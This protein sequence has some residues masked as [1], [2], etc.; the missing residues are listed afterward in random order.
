MFKMF[1]TFIMIFALIGLVSAETQWGY[2]ND[3]LPNNEDSCIPA[4]IINYSLIPTVNNTLCWQGICID[5]TTWVNSFGFLTSFTE[6]DPYYFSNPRNYLN[7]TTLPTLNPF[8]QVLNTTSNVTFNKLAVTGN[9]VSTFGSSTATGNYI[10]VVGSNADATYDVFWGERKYPRITLKDTVVTGQTFSIWNLGSQLRFGTKT[11]VAGDSAFYV[12]AGTGGNA[13][14]NGDVGIGSSPT[15]RL[16]L[17]AG[18]ST[19]WKAPLK[20]TN[21]TSLA[22]PEAGAM[23]FTTDNLFFTITTGTARKRLLMADDVGGL[24]TN[25]IPFATTNGRLTDYASFF[26]DGSKIISVGGIDMSGADS[27]ANPNNGVFFGGGDWEIYATYDDDALHFSNSISGASGYDYKFDNMK[28][29]FA[30]SGTDGGIILGGS[31][32]AL[33]QFD[34]TNLVF[35]SGTGVSWF[36]RNVSATGYITRTSVFDSTKGNALDWIKNASSYLTPTEEINH[37]AFYGYTKYNATDYSKPVN[38]SYLKKNCTINNETQENICKNIT[39]YKTIYP[40]QTMEEG[41]DLGKEIDVLRQ[42]TYDLNNKITILQSENQMLKDCIK[43]SLD[44]KSL[45][46]CIR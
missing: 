13:I 23:E 21:G 39:Q 1:L 30:D 46:L 35:N 40:Y 12:T 5:P 19:L 7:E 6:L 43:N 10:K 41:V 32:Q 22:T 24:T 25:R 37:S 29:W 3:N 18:T 2:C 14:F 28:V 20:F 16:L 36:N 9:N 11:D 31:Q 42:G 26:W 27:E 17:P 44:F 4:P 45:Q 33:I 8:N 15:A 38:Q 34:D